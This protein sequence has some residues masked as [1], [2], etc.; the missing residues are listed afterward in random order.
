MIM[1]VIRSGLTNSCRAFAAAA[2]LLVVASNAVA[3][4]NAS[5]PNTSQPNASK[6]PPN[7]LQGFSQNRG[8]PVQIEAGAL[9]VRD[10]DKVATFSGNVKVVQGDTTLRC[11]ALVVF[12]EQQGQAAGAPAMKAATP[13][14]GGSSQ[15]SRL[16][17]TG[18]VTVNQKEQTATGDSALFDMKAN[19]VTL[20]GNVVVSQGQNVMRG[21]R[22]V[23]NLTT[24][25]SQVL[26]GQSSPVKVLIQQGGSGADGKPGAPGA[27]S[28]P[29]F[30]P[31]F[32]PPKQN[33]SN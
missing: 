25:V 9:E 24:G 11:K 15:I 7:A 26:A 30:G 18:G 32:G 33:S 4:P 31:S 17:A 19:T 20:K 5:Q 6:G 27:G 8:Q 10:K 12:Y 3:Q 29:K 2:M 1:R 23:V 14:P 28:G 21:D 13:G 22:L 16:E